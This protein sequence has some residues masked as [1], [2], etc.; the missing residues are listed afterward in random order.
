MRLKFPKLNVGSAAKIVKFQGSVQNCSISLSCQSK[1][2]TQRSSGAVLTSLIN[3]SSPS[4]ICCLL[5]SY[6][7]MV[8]ESE[9]LKLFLRPGIFDL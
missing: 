1:L 4:V 3:G 2:R 6:K 8:R 5:H 7:R 9:L